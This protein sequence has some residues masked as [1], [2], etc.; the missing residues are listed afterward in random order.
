MV[1]VLK[2][3]L[4]FSSCI[5]SVKLTMRGEKRI[6]IANWSFVAK[7]EVGAAARRHSSGISGKADRICRRNLYL[8]S[9][10]RISSSELILRD[11]H[12]PTYDV[13][14]V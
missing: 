13:H 12:A 11:V 8:A 2:I 1:T 7:A 9:P 10:L 4:F 6:G 5:T 3:L 14:C